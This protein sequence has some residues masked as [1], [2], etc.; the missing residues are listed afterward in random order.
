M[1]MLNSAAFYTPS[2]NIPAIF[3]I[4]LGHLS[5]IL[6]KFKYILNIPTTFCLNSWTLEPY[7]AAILA[8]AWLHSYSIRGTFQSGAIPS[9]IEL[10]MAFEV[11]SEYYDSILNI[12]TLFQ[13]HS[14]ANTLRMCKTHLTRVHSE[15]IVFER[16]S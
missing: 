5:Y 4:H 3:L 8:A 2:E 13:L 14:R 16:H 6:S 12:P 11:H 9:A 1:K 10:H 15:F 7:S